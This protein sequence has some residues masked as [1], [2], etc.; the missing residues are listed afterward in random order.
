MI[1]KFLIPLGVVVIALFGGFALMATAPK[2]EPTAPEP[3]PTAVRVTTVTSQPVRLAVTS[4]GTVSPNVESQLIPEVPGRIVWMS[5]SLIPGGYFEA[6]DVL[7]RL[8]DQD[9]V[10][11]VS[12]AKASLTRAEAEHQHARFEY[13]RLRSLSDR[14]LAS[15]SQIENALRSFR[16]S[17]AA[18]RDAQVAHSQAQRDLSRGE[19]TAPFT[20]LVRSKNVDI[21]QFVQRGNPVATIYASD[22]V[23]VRLPIAD[24]QLAYLSLPIGHRGRLPD[25]GQ[26]TVTLSADYGGQRLEWQGKVVRTEAE[27]DMKSRMVRVVARV[28]NAEQATPLAVGLFV[29]A[30]IDGILEEDVIELPRSALRNGNQVLVVDDESRLR[31]R[32]IVPLRLYQDKVLIREGLV[33]GERVC[34]SALQTV[35]DGMRVKPFEE[36]VPETATAPQPVAAVN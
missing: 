19:I 33:T 24:A 28:N 1:K 7:L 34:I 14:Q 26:P 2:L 22:V 6:G 18:L 12:R 31:Y 29:N 32:E 8:D 13:Q 5:P 36:G 17:E 10:D 30:S 20:G 27:I 4:Q 9:L 15:R 23:E 11:T 35:I 25:A 16:I 21:G 3:I